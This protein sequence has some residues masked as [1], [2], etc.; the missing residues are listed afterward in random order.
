MSEQEKESTGLPSVKSQEASMR[1]E[2][3]EKFNSPEAKKKKE[4]EDI[5]YFLGVITASI[6]IHYL[7]PFFDLYLVVMWVASIII[8]FKPNDEKR[9]LE[10]ELEKIMTSTEGIE[11]NG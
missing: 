7:F 9:K 8:R 1:N 11:Q 4:R 6:A 10:N 2:L 3:W 5:A